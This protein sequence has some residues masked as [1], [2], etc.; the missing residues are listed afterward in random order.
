MPPLAPLLTLPTVADNEVRPC[1]KAS[2]MRWTREAPAPAVLRPLAPPVPIITTFEPGEL[3]SACFESRAQ[4]SPIGPTS[5]R[6]RRVGAAD[7]TREPACSVCVQANSA[8]SCACIVSA[9]SRTFSSTLSRPCRSDLTWAR[10]LAAVDAAAS[11]TARTSPCDVQGNSV[12]S[13]SFYF[14]YARKMS[15]RGGVDTQSTR[16]Q[17]RVGVAKL[18]QL[19]LQRPVSR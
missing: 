10:E 2:S 4:P 5:G 19:A 15:R 16:L 14:H 11:A 6:R 13:M 12:A 18:L 17:L 8:F 1:S 9:R 3:S 7:T